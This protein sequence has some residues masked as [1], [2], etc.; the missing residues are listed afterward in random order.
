MWWNFDWES[1]AVFHLNFEFTAGHHEILVVGQEFCCDGDML[2]RFSRDLLEP[3]LLTEENFDCALTNNC[4][5][6]TCDN[7]SE[8]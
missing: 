3:K 6:V 4:P 2:I 1:E 5:G 7:N 8:Y